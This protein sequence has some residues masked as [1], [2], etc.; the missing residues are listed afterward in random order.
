MLLQQSESDQ[1]G[2]EDPSVHHCPLTA[3]SSVLVFCLFFF[4]L[5]RAAS[6]IVLHLLHPDTVIICTPCTTIYTVCLKKKKRPVP[7]RHSQAPATARVGVHGS[8]GLRVSPARPIVKV[9]EA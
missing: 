4:L 3:H 9:L 8:S 1:Y 6:E 2:L 5:R 7:V